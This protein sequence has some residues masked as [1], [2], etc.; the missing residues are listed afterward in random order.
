[1]W[2][3]SIVDEV[4]SIRRAMLADCADDLNALL[5]RLAREN[6]AREGRVRSVDELNQRFPSTPVDAKALAALGEPWRD[7]IVEEVRRAREQIGE[8]GL[9]P[10]KAKSA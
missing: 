2:R 1:M 8:S 9:R 10:P 3:D 4:D 5:Q 7:P 6:R